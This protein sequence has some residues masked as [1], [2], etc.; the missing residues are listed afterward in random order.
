M[1]Q[2]LEDYF[3]SEVKSYWYKQE[4]YAECEKYFGEIENIKVE[5]TLCPSFIV[6]LKDHTKEDVEVYLD[7]LLGFIY[8]QNK[9]KID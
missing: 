2:L 5:A 8:S 1:K 3:G 9:N 7:E 6:K 4:V